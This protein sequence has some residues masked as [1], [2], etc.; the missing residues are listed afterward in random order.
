MLSAALPVL[1]GQL[2]AV[3]TGYIAVRPCIAD[4]LARAL[5]IDAVVIALPASMQ[6]RQPHKLSGPCCACAITAPGS[7][8]PSRIAEHKKD[9]CQACA[10]ASI[11]FH[12]PISYQHCSLQGHSRMGKWVGVS[13]G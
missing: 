10:S 2:L 12:L 5:H 1:S 6:A 8:Q 11:G 3:S 7:C 9:G 13:H 4:L